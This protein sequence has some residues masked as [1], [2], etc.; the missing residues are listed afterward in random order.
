MKKVILISGGTEGLGKSTAKTLS[1]KNNVII[2]SPSEQKLKKVSKQLS[3]DFRICDISNWED[4]SQAIKS[5]KN[6]YKK[7]DCLINN[8]SL[9][10]EQ[11]LE[12]NSPEYI[13]RVNEVNITGTEF[14]TKAVIPIMKKQK[15]G[16]IINIDSQAGLVGQNGKSIYNASKGAIHIFT[17]S[18]QIELQKYNIQ[19]TGIYPGKINTNM[20]KNMGI[21]KDMSNALDPKYVTKLIEFILSFDSKVVFPEIGIKHPNN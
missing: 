21:K 11:E 10:I 12:L 5:I 14:L 2:L 13:K 8:A 3:C 15:N 6:Q 16:L 19:V 17:K 20:F 18:L 9:Y 1:K 4:V 7:I